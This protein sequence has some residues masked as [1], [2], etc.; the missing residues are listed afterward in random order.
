MHCL[1]LEERPNERQRAACGKQAKNGHGTPC[2]Y[3][4]RALLCETK[5]SKDTAVAQV[6]ERRGGGRGAG[7][8]HKQLF[9]M[10]FERT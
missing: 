8:W 2:P 3:R 10:D 7:D 9:G 1:L 5:S 4:R 6:A